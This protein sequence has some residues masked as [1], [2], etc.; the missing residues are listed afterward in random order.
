MQT[1]KQGLAE[2]CSYEGMS[3]TKYLDSVNVQTIGLGATV[4][5]IP[6][7]HNWA[8]DKEMP[9]QQCFDLFKQG[10]TKYEAGVNSHVTVD[11]TQW[12]F[13]ALV[14]IAYNIGTYGEN[15]STFLRYINSKRSDRE[16]RQAIMAW[17]KQKELIRRRTNEANLYIDGVYNNDGTLNLFPVNTTT[18][19]PMYGKGTIIHSLDYL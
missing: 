3:T 1:S 2:I 14:S 8:W 5:E 10:I 7:L 6:D 18:H 19:K 4:S 16:I 11:L 13:D 12:E 17:T 9:I 15:H